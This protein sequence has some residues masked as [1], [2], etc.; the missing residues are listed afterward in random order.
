MSDKWTPCPEL[1]HAIDAFAAAYGRTWRSTLFTFW[2]GDITQKAIRIPPDQR[3]DLQALRNT[4]G[5]REFVS[6]Y[7][8]A[9]R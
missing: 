7:K 3:S 8:P 5:G 1:L 6:K 4:P 2:A 9:K